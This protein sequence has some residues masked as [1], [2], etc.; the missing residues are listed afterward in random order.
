AVG[1]AARRARPNV[2]ARMR[3]HHCF[4]LQFRLRENLGYNRKL[5]S[6]LAQAMSGIQY[7]ATR[8][9]ALAAPSYDIV[10]FMKTRPDLDRVDARILMAPCTTAPLL[11]A[12]PTPLA[13]QP[14]LQP[15]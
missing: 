6:P 5:S 13:R 14:C 7:L 10:G 8:R 15:I 9:G 2:G 3:E 12:T 4:A 1:I 11:P